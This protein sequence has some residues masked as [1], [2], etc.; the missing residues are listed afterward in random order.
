MADD[1]ADASL[2]LTED[3]ELDQA[4]DAGGG[5]ASPASGD[6]ENS[7]I[8]EMRAR[9]KELQR[10]SSSS[11]TGSSRRPSSW[12]R[13][14][15]L[16]GA[17]TLRGELSPT[18]SRPTLF[19]PTHRMASS[20][21]RTGKVC[22]TDINLGKRSAIAITANPLDP[23]ISTGNHLLERALARPTIA[24]RADPVSRTPPQFRCVNAGNPD[25]LGA[26]AQTVAIGCNAKS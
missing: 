26:A 17:T 15:R 10:T 14:P 3:M 5:D 19:I 1:T 24:R 21:H 9:I 16:P 8:L 22:P 18:F 20:D 11:I 13:S 23:Q 12:V 4:D 6:G 7:T 25:T 2:E